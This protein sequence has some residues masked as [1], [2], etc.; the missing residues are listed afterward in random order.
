MNH[1]TGYSA[2]RLDA[3]SSWSLPFRLVSAVLRN[4]RIRPAPWLYVA[5]AA[6]GSLLGV[7]AQW[8]FG[9][10]WWLVAAAAVGAVVLFFV[11]TAFWGPTRQDLAGDLLREISLRE[12][13]LR[14]RRIE[15][16]RFR[17][18]PFPLYG[19]PPSWP[20]ARYL[21]SSAHASGPGIPP[22]VTAL[23]LGHGAPA[24]RDTAYLHVE[25]LADKTDRA[26]HRSELAEWLWLETDVEEP[27]DAAWSTATIAVD[28]RPVDFDLLF[29]GENWVALAEVGGRPVVLSARR[30]DVETVE[31]VR[32]SDVEPYVRRE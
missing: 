29:C 4:R 24:G 30:F 7:A 10:P 3:R 21:S 5:A 27:A 6:A 28:G 20:G 18:A 17:A 26:A 22:R 13:D 23:E 15:T 16:D 32:I 25:T 12:A 1:G 8:A 2:Y 9:W 31:L 11:S 19:L 14:A